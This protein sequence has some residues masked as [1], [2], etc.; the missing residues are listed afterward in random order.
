MAV[1]RAGEFQV[2]DTP[3]A[4]ADAPAADAA[5]SSSERAAS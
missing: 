1:P 4:A 2:T 5:P 3:V